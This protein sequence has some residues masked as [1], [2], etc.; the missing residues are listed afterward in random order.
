[1]GTA[2]VHPQAVSTLQKGSTV[3][4]NGSLSPSGVAAPSIW[5]LLWPPRTALRAAVARAASNEAA[6]SCCKQRWLVLQATRL[7]HR[8]TTSND[9]MFSPSSALPSVMSV[10]TEWK[11]SAGGLAVALSGLR[12]YFFA[13]AAAISRFDIFRKG[14]Q[15]QFHLAWLRCVC[16]STQTSGVGRERGCA[17]FWPISHCLTPKKK[18][19]HSPAE[20]LRS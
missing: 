3:T 16:E 20:N 8:A 12:T 9:G 10:M 6:A 15:C 5:P 19:K 4:P 11:R 2:P 14:P 1:M 17:I 7:P 13:A 18:H